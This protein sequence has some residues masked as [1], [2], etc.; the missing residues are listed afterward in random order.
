MLDCELESHILNYHEFFT[1]RMKKVFD[2]AETSLANFRNID[3]IL[4]I[5]LILVMSYSFSYLL[6]WIVYGGMENFQKYRGEIEDG[7]IEQR[8]QKKKSIPLSKRE[9]S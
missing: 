4:L 8:C 1:G 9:D 5:A 7:V 2:L 6:I 3:I